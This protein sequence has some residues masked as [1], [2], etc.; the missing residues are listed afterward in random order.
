MS[1]ARARFRTSLRLAWR[2]ITH[3][4]SYPL[5]HLIVL[6]VFF[7]ALRTAEDIS[8]KGILETIP[9]D[10]G[11]AL[12]SLAGILI[13]GASASRSPGAKFSELEQSFP[14]GSEVILGRS[15]ASFMASILFLIEPLLFAALNGP[16][17]SFLS[18]LPIYLAE[19]CLTVA[20]PVALVWLLAHRSGLPTWSYPLLGMVWLGFFGLGYLTPFYSNPAFGLLNFMRQGGSYYSEMWGRLL[21]DETPRW[22]D[23]FYFGL[24]VAAL[25]LLWLVQTA[26][27]LHRVPAAAPLLLAASLVLSGFSAVQYSGITSDWLTNH[28]PW[29][30]TI[31]PAAYEPRQ[32]VAEPYPFGEPPA[33]EVDVR[34]YDLTLDFSNETPKFHA[35]LELGN[36]QDRALQEFVLLL[37]G[38][39]ALTESS[40]P[41]E[42]QGVWLRCSAPEPFAPGGTLRLELSYEGTVHEAGMILSRDWQL[43]DFILDE[44]LR[45][46]PQAAWY[47]I[48]YS[49]SLED[50]G[51]RNDIFLLRKPAHVTLEVIQ[52]ASHPYPLASNLPSIGT[53]RFETQGTTWIFLIGSPNLIEEPIGDVTLVTARADLQAVKG[54]M[55]RYREI[56]ETYRTIFPAVNTH[57]ALV[58]ALG[59][60]LGLPEETRTPPTLEQPVIIASRYVL[61]SMGAWDQSLS[62]EYYLGDAVLVDLWLLNRATQLGDE[63]WSYPTMLWQVNHSPV[64]YATSSFLWEY[65]ESGGDALDLAERIDARIAARIADRAGAPDDSPFSQVVNGLLQVYQQGGQAGL[66]HAINQLSLM[67]E[68][69]YNTLYAENPEALRQWIVEAG[70]A[71]H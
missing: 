36:D 10:I 43:K 65:Y 29:V 39:L 40:L 13:A 66:V 9:G 23:L 5:A 54:A 60:E 22:A 45:L 24:G 34:N 28:T 56:Y 41:C 17:D 50:Q 31:D 51:V 71:A 69:T 49:P 53:N 33:V 59:E 70:N 3:H 1:D 46:S 62:E 52:S 42:K 57:T 48:P 25:V 19:G 26:N 58:M 15:L 67:S 63:A 32:H 21:L 2:Q 14:G 35:T 6:A 12:A 27:R 38:R 37:N 61:W 44:G 18:E 47:P 30:Q 16:W 55:E 8:A 11:I 68:E 7:I 4:W 64:W 20:L